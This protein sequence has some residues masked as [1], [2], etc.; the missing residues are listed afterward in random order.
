MPE[1]HPR[2]QIQ[3]TLE[4]LE[5]SIE[6]VR[7]IRDRKTGSFTRHHTFPAH[8]IQRNRVRPRS[9]S[10]S[11][12]HR[13]TPLLPPPF[14]F[15]LHTHIPSPHPR[16]ILSGF[17]R[18][19]AFVKFTS[20]E[21]AR[22]FMDKRYPYIMM[23]DHRVRIDYSHNSGAG[24]D[25]AWTCRNCAV[26]NYKKR[27]TC[28]QCS[29]PMQESIPTPGQTAY[30][31]HPSAASG[32]P[33]SG[34][35]AADYG[36]N[37][38]TR[39][40]G[41]APHHVLLVR[42]LDNLTTGEGVHA[43]FVALS[44]AV[45]RTLLVK[46]RMSRM[47]WGFAFVEFPD[48]QVCIPGLLVDGR[49][50]T[51][52]FAHPNSLAPVYVPSEWTVMGDAGTVLTYWDEQ[53]YPCEFVVPVGGAVETEKDGKEKDGNEGV[54]GKVEKGAGMKEEKEKGMLMLSV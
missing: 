52:S 4:S 49:S 28:F 46:D 7:L 51:V 34:S 31:H 25:E 44:S 47:S 3:Q 20:V 23:N 41:H 29:L 8:G 2:N 21:H 18:C 12:T 37:D 43:A 24:D 6:N 10:I 39:D 11:L 22:Q 50:V 13:V 17:S 54:A 35:G 1:R 48:V 40:V 45:R 27:A 38:G 42:G 33:A 26:L 32:S 15:R 30:H 53:A 36:I 9:A 5:A 16:P 14:L 19:F